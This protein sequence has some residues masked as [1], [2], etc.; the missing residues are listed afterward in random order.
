VTSRSA[1]KKAAASQAASAKSSRATEV[2]NELRREIRFLSKRGRS[3]LERL[4]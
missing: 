1:T 4:G 3:L 2:L